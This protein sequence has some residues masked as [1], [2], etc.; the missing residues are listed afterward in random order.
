[1]KGSV[2]NWDREVCLSVCL[3]RNSPGVGRIIKFLF[4]LVWGSKQAVSSP[5][6]LPSYPNN[7][8]CQYLFLSRLGSKGLALPTGSEEEMSARLLT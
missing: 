1:M 7:S 6:P 4:S 5:P 2:L 3:V 8:S